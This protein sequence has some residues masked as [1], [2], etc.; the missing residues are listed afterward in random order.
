MGTIAGV[1][2]RCEVCPEL[3]PRIKKVCWRYQSRISNVIQEKLLALVNHLS[4]PGSSEIEQFDPA[5]VENASHLLPSFEIS[6]DNVLKESFDPSRNAIIT[7][8]Q[9]DILIPMARSSCGE[10][11]Q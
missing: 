11:G 1:K 5:F 6:E 2:I 7:C 9:Q 10:R 3:G 4:P 8:I